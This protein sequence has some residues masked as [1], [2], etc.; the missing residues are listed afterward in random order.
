MSD[1]DVPPAPQETPPPIRKR[2]LRR[3]RLWILIPLLLLLVSGSG[4][5]MLS[6]TYSR[7]QTYFSKLDHETLDTP[8]TRRVTYVLETLDKIPG[9]G[10]WILTPL[11]T[12]E[13]FSP[14]DML[15]DLKVQL[16]QSDFGVT[17]TADEFHRMTSNR[18]IL[19]FDA[20]NKKLTLDQLQELSR[21]TWLTELSVDLHHLEEPD[22]LDQAIASLEKIRQLKTLQLSVENSP[23]GLARWLGKLSQLQD[24]DL[25][26][27][28]ITPEVMQSIASL[29]NLREL[30]LLGS[31]PSNASSQLIVK[32]LEP[33]A[34]P[35][36][37]NFTKL[38][39]TAGSLPGTEQI[40]HQLLQNPSLTEV[41]LCQLDLTD[42]LV[43]DIVALKSL[44]SLGLSRQEVKTSHLRTLTALPRLK[45]LTLPFSKLEENAV[46]VLN[47]ASHLET[48]DLRWTNLPPTALTKLQPRPKLHLD[49]GADLTPTDTPSDVTQEGIVEK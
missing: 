47:A 16:R 24:L 3:W 13:N 1:T 44:T 42:K 12:S 9:F 23:P 30:N 39:I 31:F 22:K 28:N 35:R 48:I 32:H 19:A 21:M 18:N 15:I 37:P 38:R 8:R 45:S 41:H 33:G 4:L 34:N 5:W 14:L 7:S 20:A 49:V 27:R 26:Y 40:V 46:E 36:F 2:W 11:L 6:L 29:K 17:L 10:D 43:A 25:R